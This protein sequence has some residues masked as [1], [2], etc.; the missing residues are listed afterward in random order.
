MSLKVGHRTRGVPRGVMGW[1]VL[2]PT[3]GVILPQKPSLNLIMPLAL[4]TGL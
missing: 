4:T 2:G 1:E 3:Q